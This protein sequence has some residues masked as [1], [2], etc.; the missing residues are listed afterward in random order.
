MALVALSN[1]WPENL[2]SLD[3]VPPLLLVP[4]V[5]PEVERDIEGLDE[6]GVAASAI[7]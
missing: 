3:E 6:V 2:S 1:V 5:V 7:L 4:E